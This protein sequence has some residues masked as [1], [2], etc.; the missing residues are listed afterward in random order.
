[1]IARAD[2]SSGKAL[3]LGWDPR[4]ALAV[5]RSLGRGGVAVHLA[6]CPPGEIARASRYV[7]AAHELPSWAEGTAWLEPLADLMRRERFDLVLPCHDETL[8]PLQAHRAALE[9]LGRIALLDDDIYNLTSDKIAMHA[10]AVRLGLDVPPGEPIADADANAAANA[11][12]A[13]A[14]AARLGWPVV[15]KPRR[16]YDPADLADLAHRRTVRIARDAGEL[17][18]LLPAMLADGDVL[19]QAYVP[20]R[21]LGLEVLAQRGEILLAFAHRRLH[22]P[23]LGG[24]GSYRAGAPVD[25]ALL[26]A[27][28]R[29]IGELN[30]TG[31]AMIEFREDAQTGR[32]AFMEINNRF[33]GSLP[34]AVASGADF[35]LALYRLLVHG[36]RPAPRVP[37]A[38]LVA[39]NLLFDL[40][41]LRENFRADPADPLLLRVGAG[42]LLREL[43][44]LAVLRERWDELTLDDPAP[45]LAL[46]RRVA[47][48]LWKKTA[49][50]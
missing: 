33:W 36:E 34:L 14:A 47:R 40:R 23:P 37:R 13:R 48:G 8:A 31:V 43:G 35:P 3:V 7:R 45:A 29:L 22:E 2:N 17:E 39:R 1:M 42:Q 15:L 4:S 25:E 11:A 41:W 24:G 5:I 46:A 6:W 30:Y 19:A 18:R 16:S 27:G 50:R 28:R 32:R 20:G 12:S 49:G 26:A 21:G 9:P 10:L 38:D 44:H